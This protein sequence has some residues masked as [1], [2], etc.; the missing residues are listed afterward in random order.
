M[1]T[2]MSR[3][4]IALQLLVWAT[5]A[6]VHFAASIPAIL[7]E[8]R[9][10]IALA[11]LVRALTGLI[12]SSAMW[13]LISTRLD[14]AR[15]RWWIVIGGAAFAAGAA[16]TFIDR[17][18][19]TTLASVLRLE[20]PW[21][22]FTHGLDLDYFFV[23][24]AW[25][26]AAAGLVLAAHAQKQNEI[27]LEQQL[28]AE[29]ARLHML[30]SQLNP[31]FLFNALNTIRS[32]ASEDAEKT[33]EVVTRLSAFLRRVLS[34]DPSRPTTLDDEITLAEDYLGVERARFE[35]RLS[36]ETRITPETSGFPVPPLILQPLLENA[37]KHGIADAEGVRRIIVTSDISND[38]L[39]LKVVNR[40]DIENRGQ[41]GKGIDI[42]AT[43]LRQMY[44]ERA[45][46]ELTEES[47][48]VTATILIPGRSN[49]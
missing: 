33:R 1:M 13:P 2:Y 31:H 26:G 20:M 11:K 15:K 39:V 7:P 27:A 28:A 43:R 18:L 22:R 47:G 16:W 30:A 8:E 6:A 12:V 14:P 17:A 49:R 35:S 24:L 4:F 3:R 48:V 9:G 36:I 25:T 40:G 41:T 23:M 38:A 21:E 44:G 10:E 29:S 45:S 34:F 37:V 46:V 42:T 5:Y 32:I 19:L